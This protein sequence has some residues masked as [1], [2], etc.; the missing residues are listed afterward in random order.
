MNYTKLLIVEVVFAVLVGCG[1]DSSD[2]VTQTSD[3]PSSHET[4]F[5]PNVS[6][7]E[8]LDERDGQTY[9]TVKIVDQIWMAENLNY[10]YGVSPDSQSY[11]CFCPQSMLKNCSEYGRRYSW[12]AAMDSTGVFS[13]NGVGCGNEAACSPTYPVR[14]VCPKGWHLPDSSEFAVLIASA[15]GK[16][17]GGTKLKTTSGWEEYKGNGTDDFGFS[18]L[19]SYAHSYRSE[20]EGTGL[21]ASFWSASE[22]DSQTAYSL[23]LSQLYSVDVYATGKNFGLSVRCVKD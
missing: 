8:L 5:N 3:K 10:A 12:A 13:T 9:K 15:G 21:S 2:F 17:K 7:G 14:G 23:H 19:P 1:D 4:K 6:Y 11:D 18:A 16:S 20:Y 22:K